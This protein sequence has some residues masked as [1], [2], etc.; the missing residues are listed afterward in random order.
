M[1]NQKTSSRNTERIRYYLTAAAR[2]KNTHSS[3]IL[4][5]VENIISNLTMVY[6]H[7]LT[8]DTQKTGSEK[9]LQLL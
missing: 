3:L 5:Q 6:L 8:S 1:L 4:F 9:R 2:I 7:S